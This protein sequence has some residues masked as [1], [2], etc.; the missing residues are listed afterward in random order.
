MA[1]SQ[2]AAPASV[3]SQYAWNT[4]S[5][6]SPNG[7]LPDVSDPHNCGLSANNIPI[8]TQLGQVTRF[9]PFRRRVLKFHGIP[10]KGNHTIASS[11]DVSSAQKRQ[12]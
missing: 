5:S 2:Q 8:F 12:T 1:S 10:F 4:S 7:L 6:P 11:V 9:G 3:L